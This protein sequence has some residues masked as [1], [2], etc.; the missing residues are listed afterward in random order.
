M[1]RLLTILLTL[2]L[3]APAALA[4]AA[5]SFDLDAMTPD[6]LLALHSAVTTRVAVVNSG[7]VVYDEDGITIVWN[8]L[9][10]TKQ[11]YFKYGCTI[12]NQTG[13]NVWLR[14]TGGGIN[15]IQ[16]GPVGN[17][18]SMEIIDGMALFTGSYYAWLVSNVFR[19][20]N[21][22]HASEIYLQ[23]S[24]YVAGDRWGIEPFRVV[25]VRFPVDEEI[26]LE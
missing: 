2:V 1:R 15:G 16:M 6:E 24:F 17:T 5:P 14:I 13:E 10:D 23:V 18:D 26:V 22:T 12:Y 20:L 9:M 7:D 4:E 19:D 11:S 21:I 8:G 25:N 3:F